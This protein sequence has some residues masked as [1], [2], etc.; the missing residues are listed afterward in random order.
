METR[1]YLE[2]GDK[3]WEV[4][5]DGNSVKTRFGK[6]G[7]QGQMR[8]KDF[9]SK[10]DAAA[11]LES[12]LAKK[13]KEGFIEP[14]AAK[15]PEAKG[16]PAKSASAKTAPS[17]SNPALEKAIVANPYDN[18]AYMVYADWLQAQGD[19]R[20]ELAALQLAGKDKEAKKFLA[21]HVEALLGPLQDH[22]RTH[23][24]DLQ[25]NG[26]VNSAAWVKENQHAFRWKGGFIHRL[27]LSFS[28]WA[29]EEFQGTLAKDVLVPVLDHPSGKFVAEIAINENGES[30]DDLQDII[31]VLAKR[32]PATL[33]KLHIGDN[34]DQISWYRVGNLGKLWKAVP[35]LTHLDI[36]AGE[37]TLGTLDLPNLEH[38]VIKTGGLTKAN[39]KSIANANW[40]KIEHLE[41]YIG[42]E[43]YGASTTIKDI[44]P[45]LD[46]TDLKKL[47]YLGIKSAEFQND[48]VP[49]LAKSRLV[50]QLENLDI[51]QGVLTD[52]AFDA[53]MQHKDAWEH[54]IIDISE[55]YMSKKKW[56]Q[57][58][59]LCRLVIAKEMRADDDP[60]YRYPMVG[61]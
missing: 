38:A 9:K 10:S 3:F 58:S 23:D 1:R 36:E 14:K 18:D 33:R 53:F 44:L 61:E 2:S 52:D 11:D 15:K 45:L 48:L 40:P 50:R 39:M 60:E 55:S 37:F 8:L 51:S 12:Q 7:A 27:R 42:Q 57:L 34:V 19:P 5:V 35:K 26:R 4:F 20:G 54:L 31:D 22:Q 16:A 59:P 56:Q 47:K 24:D 30:D 41:I 32:A 46:R 29:D 25:N 13:L 28:Q 17:A 43:D 6:I 49:V 21:K